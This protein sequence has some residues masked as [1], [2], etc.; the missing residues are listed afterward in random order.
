MSR[1]RSGVVGV[2]PLLLVAG[3]LLAGCGETTWSEYS[4]AEGAFSV[5]MPGTPTEQ[6]QAQDTEMGTIDVH[7]FTFEEGDVAY[8]VG[9]NVFPAA[10]I[11]AASSDSMLDGARDG[12]V[13]AVKGTLV[14]EQKITLGAYPGRELE[15]QIEDSD[16]TLSLRSRTFLVRDRLYQVMVVGPKGQSTSPDTT[17]FLDSF[18]L[19][20]E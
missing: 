6:T 17:K 3:A 10:V 13:N 7:S 9:Y 4:S 8:L 1:K 20:E 5:L 16:G 15:I 11:G 12:Q 18:K 19:M 2:L 14:N